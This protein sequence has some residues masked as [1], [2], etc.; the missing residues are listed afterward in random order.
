MRVF[1]IDSSV[2]VWFERS[3]FLR[4]S[5]SGSV[6]YRY[7]GP[8]VCLLGWGWGNFGPGRGRG[9]WCRVG[10]R[11]CRRGLIKWPVSIT[12]SNLVL[13]LY[14]YRRKCW[15]FM[16]GWSC[17]NVRSRTLWSFFWTCWFV[18]NWWAGGRNSAISTKTVWPW[19]WS[20]YS[21]LIYRWTPK[22]RSWGSTWT[23][24]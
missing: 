5:I 16:R 24:S 13:C 23:V 1:K 19:T 4:P 8:F 11:C 12:Y 10:S 21:R 3:S 6:C 17:R 7:L 15:S 20:R 9:C 18:G 14:V 22:R 2:I